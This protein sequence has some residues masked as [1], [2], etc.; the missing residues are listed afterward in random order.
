MKKIAGTNLYHYKQISWGGANYFCVI[1]TTGSWGSGNWSSGNRTNAQYY[2][3]TYGD[4]RFDSGSYYLVTKENANKNANIDINYIGNS[5]NSYTA[6][7]HAQ[8]ITIEGEGT[9]A[10][11]TYKLTAAS[12]AT[13]SS[14]TTSADAAYTATVTCTATP[15][16]G[17]EFLGWYDAE[18]NLV[19]TATTY[20][21]TAPHAD[22]K[23]TAKFSEVVVATPAI[24]TFTAEPSTIVLGESVTLTSTTENTTNEVVYTVNEEVITSPWTP[25]AVGTY[26]ITAS[27]EGAESKTATV[28]VNAVPVP[29][30][31]SFTAEPAEITL[32]ESVTLT[33]TTENTTENVVYTVNDEVITSPW[34][35]A[36]V[37]TYT[38]T[39][40]LEGAES[41]TA[42][43][44]VNAVPVPAIVTF[45]AEPSTIVLGEEVTFTCEVENADAADVEYTI[46]GN[47]ITSPWTPGAVGTYEITA[48]LA[49]AAET[50]TAT[51]TV[52][53]APE[54][55]TWTFYYIGGKTKV[56]AYVWDQGNDSKKYL[57]EWPGSAMT[58]NNGVWEISFTTT[59]VLVTPMVIFNEGNNTQTGDLALENGATYD[60]NGKTDPIDTTNNH[61]V[62]FTNSKNWDTVSVY[63]WNLETDE[64]YLGEWP[65]STAKEI[66][67]TTW[68]YTT[69]SDL[70]GAGL[71]FNNGNN[72]S[73]TTDLTWKDNTT[74]DADG[75]TTT[76]TKPVEEEAG[77]YFVTGTNDNW[78]ECLA[79]TSTDGNIYTY[80]G[81]LKGGFKFRL[82][83]ESDNGQYGANSD[84]DLQ[85]E[86][87]KTYGMKSTSS[88]DAK[89]F[90]TP[91]GNPINVTIE[92]NRALN[93]V[94]V[95]PADVYIAG[96]AV[97]EKYEASDVG[98]GS[99]GWGVSTIQG[100]DV[101]LAS[102]TYTWTGYLYDDNGDGADNSRFKFLLGSGFANGGHLIPDVATTDINYEEAYNLSFSWDDTSKRLFHSNGFDGM[103]TYDGAAVEGETRVKVKAVIDLV[104]MKV[105]FY[106]VEEETFEYIFIAGNATEYGV[107]GRGALE[108]TTGENGEAV[109][110]AVVNFVSADEGFLFP[111]TESALHPAFVAREDGKVAEHFALQGLDYS[112]AS[113]PINNQFKVAGAG[114]YKVEVRPDY[115]SLYVLPYESTSP[116]DGTYLTVAEKTQTETMTVTFFEKVSDFDASK[117]IITP[118]TWW[119]HYNGVH[120]EGERQV[121]NKG[122]SGGT[123]SFGVN[124]WDG[125]LT[126]GETY[127]ITFEQGAVT[128]AAKGLA[129][130]VS[131]EFSFTVTLAPDTSIGTGIEGV[132]VENG[133]A[134]KNGIVTAEGT[135]VV[136]NMS[137][138]VVARGENE[139]DLN[140]MNGGVYIVRC[141]DNVS[142]VV[143]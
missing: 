53:A 51:V 133:I 61:T 84:N 5:S 119:M 64:K 10:I 86:I 85:I 89:T 7:N 95:L 2:T 4:Y 65:G 134:Y 123:V 132:T 46:D 94:R 87:G 142:K 11:S 122:I 62:Y 125:C 58:Y 82:Y 22:V 60:D 73:Q 79:M 59:D 70:N 116:A 143:R 90:T 120:I 137:G 69:T 52:T 1:G 131:P 18:G 42:T 105:T 48:T 93:T 77:F 71:I 102:G 9:T 68:A 113:N 55:I 118:E 24:L 14:G 43:V 78:N 96:S 23:L 138:A 76:P 115:N 15:D 49:G 33:S 106:P 67:D 50:K 44:I 54:E 74:Y 39:A 92:V 56:H 36:A 32:G 91:N 29:A 13:A 8:N 25:A 114:V 63:A 12:T 30:I 41:K 26:T 121:L 66:N 107:D 127:T 109:Y 27:L 130:R 38:I 6:L 99:T 135:I 81:P 136:Y 110:T 47:K 88:N 124:S 108:P 20:T 112:F 34:T 111:T 98:G 31:T 72:G 139:V 100:C 80:T 16:D 103:E 21:Y 75:N 17:A 3:N 101:D 140:G 35:P 129:E 83:K 128:F 40:S 19:S 45:T 37:G 57:G 28:T 141:N 117:V 104:N 126:T 97:V